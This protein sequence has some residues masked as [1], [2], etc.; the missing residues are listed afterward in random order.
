MLSICF[1]LVWQQRVVLSSVVF[2][3]I[4]TTTPIL[5][6][7]TTSGMASL[8]LTTS[9][10]H[11]LA[12]DRTFDLVL[13]GFLCLTLV[14]T[15][16]FLRLPLLHRRVTVLDPSCPLMPVGVMLYRV[17]HALAEVRNPVGPVVFGAC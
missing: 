15:L 13:H 14:P 12:N 9:A 10:L 3:A 11:A 4:A 17:P 6:P 2:L 8:L 7:P 5:L 16:R 1:D